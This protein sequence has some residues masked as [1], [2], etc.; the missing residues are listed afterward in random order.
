MTSFNPYRSYNFQDKDPVIDRIRTVVQDSRMTYK[1]IREIS[2]VST[3]C[4]RGWF[5]GS[6]RRPSFAT[7]TAVA[8]ALG[9]DFYLRQP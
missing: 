4:L 9:Y 1:E 5:E 2:G 7:L 8:R 6:T 3:G